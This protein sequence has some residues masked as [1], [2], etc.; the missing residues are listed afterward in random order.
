M[1][2]HIK[3]YLTLQK[4]YLPRTRALPPDSPT[5]Y[6]NTVVHNSRNSYNSHKTTYRIPAKSIRH[7]EKL[8]AY[9]PILTTAS[10]ESAGLLSKRI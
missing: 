6:A 8:N 7:E 3:T 1:I 2:C 9:K 10:T 5:Q 4:P